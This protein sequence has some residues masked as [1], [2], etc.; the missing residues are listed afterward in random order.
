MIKLIGSMLI[1]AG[2]FLCGYMSVC[3]MQ[4]RVN[5]LN[6]IAASLCVM[7]SEI[8][9]RLTPMPELLSMLSD[10][11]FYPA[12]RLYLRAAQE[13]GKLGEMSFSEIWSRAVEAENGLI[14]SP[15]ERR[16]LRTLGASLGKYSTYEQKKAVEFARRK[17]EECAQ[18]AEY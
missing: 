4:R 8:A 5:G 2:T 6:S 16:I 11:M 7:E 10:E 3:K 12:S 1:I 9:D 15:D 14:L 18:K 17:I 13:L